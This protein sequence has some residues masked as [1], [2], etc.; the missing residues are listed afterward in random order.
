M[1]IDEQKKIFENWIGQYERLFYK[2]IRT[3]AQANQDRDDLF[4]QIM[5]ELWTSIPN[6]QNTT[7]P[8]TWIYRVALNTALVWQRKKKKHRHKMLLDFDQ[9]IDTQNS[10]AES[11]PDGQVMDRLYVAIRALSKIDSSIILMH[12]DG[13]TYRQIADILGISANHVGVKLNRAK[14]LLAQQ[15]KGLI[16]DI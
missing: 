3:Y 15:L 6:C 16:D 7:T 8:T 9:I 11:S 13:L 5:L 12:L 4:Q 14:K 1:L 2:I 10:G